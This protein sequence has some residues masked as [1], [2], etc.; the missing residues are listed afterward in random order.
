MH[1]ALFQSDL[2]ITNPGFVKDVDFDISRKI[3][4]ICIDFARGCRLR[5]DDVAGFHLVRD[6]V[7]K[8]DRLS[9]FSH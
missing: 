9:N 2:G 3:L 4:S 8:R 1:A 5:V 7:I 6:M